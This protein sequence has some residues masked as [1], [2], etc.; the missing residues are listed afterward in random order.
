MLDI[1]LP[2]NLEEKKFKAECEAMFDCIHQEIEER[3]KVL[4]LE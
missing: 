1:N 4:I 2:S 3:K